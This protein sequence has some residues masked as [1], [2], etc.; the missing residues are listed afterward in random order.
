VLWHPSHTTDEALLRQ[1][2][3]YGCG[4]AAV[5]TKFMTHRSTAPAVLRRLPAGLKMLLSPDSQKNEG[6][7]DAFPPE[8][9]RAEWRGLRHGPFAYA[10]SV[11]AQ[12]QLETHRA[13]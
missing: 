10:E 3:D 13:A 6:R 1:L 2:Q 8:L 7:S 9:R 11:R 5:F 4:L 12:R